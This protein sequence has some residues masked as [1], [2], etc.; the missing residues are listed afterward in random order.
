LQLNLRIVVCLD[1]GR[2]ELLASRLAANPALQSCCVGMAWP[3]WGDDTLTAM[4]KA[5]LE[6]RAQLMAPP[7]CGRVVSVAPT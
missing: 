1:T 5:R 7:V 6:V 2:P 4:A 3:G